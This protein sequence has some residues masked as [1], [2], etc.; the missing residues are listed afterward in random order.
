MVKLNKRLTTSLKFLACVPLVDG[1]FH[2][3]TFINHNQAF[4]WLSSNLFRIFDQIGQIMNPQ[5][6]KKLKIFLLCICEFYITEFF[7]LVSML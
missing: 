6:S 7:K 3:R 1:W 5:S 4:I 2:H